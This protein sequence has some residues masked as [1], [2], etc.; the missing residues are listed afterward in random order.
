MIIINDTIE[1]VVNDITRIFGSSA[2]DDKIKNPTTGL[3]TVFLNQD[4]VTIVYDA[5]SLQLVR[6]EVT[7]VKR[8]TISSFRFGKLIIT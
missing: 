1:T 5:Q 2:I 4:L 7:E 8:Y 3:Y 6:I